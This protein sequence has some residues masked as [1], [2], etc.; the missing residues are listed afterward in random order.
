MAKIILICGRICSGKSTYAAKLRK[1]LKAVTLSCDE[2]MLAMLDPYLGDAHEMYKARRE[3]Y[4]MEKA[5]EIAQTGIDVIM[6][7]GLWTKES[8]MRSRRYFARA[9][10]ETE[11]HYLDV[12]DSEWHR[13]IEK[14]NRRVL[15]GRSTAYYVDENLAAKFRARFE[16]P[17][18]EEADLWV[19]G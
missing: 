4:I 13:R 5:V 18:P 3:K 11:L 12:E 14:R 6:D 16:K 8:R 19:Q 9:G 1:E 15:A 17:L 2:I 10:L 7:R